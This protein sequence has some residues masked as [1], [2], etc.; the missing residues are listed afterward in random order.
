MESPLWIHKSFTLW[1]AK[2]GYYHSHIFKAGQIIP[3]YISSTKV[4]SLCCHRSPDSRMLLLTLQKAAGWKGQPSVGCQ[5]WPSMLQSKGMRRETT[6]AGKFLRV[7]PSN[8]GK[9]RSLQ[10]LC[11][12][13]CIHI[14]EVSVISTEPKLSSHETV[15]LPP[16]FRPLLLSL[17]YPMH[18]TADTL[19]QRQQQQGYSSTS[20]RKIKVVSL[21]GS[22]HLQPQAASEQK[23]KKENLFQWQWITSAKSEIYK[24]LTKEHLRVT[25][26]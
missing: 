9:G 18:S 4:L 3:R 23:G 20:N 21:L 16:L 1:L 26:Q 6:G 11:A 10:S 5:F 15:P 7:C 25:D 24:L 22:H 12:C 2:T 17:N 13:P 8:A 19:A 14:R